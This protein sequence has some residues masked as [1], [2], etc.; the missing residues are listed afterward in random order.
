MTWAPRA[1]QRV[2]TAHFGPGVVTRATKGGALVR[3]E[4][5]GGYEIEV[6]AGELSPADG[7][8]GERPAA[9]VGVA[10]PAAAPVAGDLAARRAIEALRFGL[11]PHQYLE[12]LTLGFAELR[13][14]TLRNFPAAHDDRPRVA[15]I[16]G[17]FGT[18]KSHT[19][20]VIRHLAGCEGYVT[21][22][23]EVD[24]QQISLAKPETFLYQLWSTAAAPDLS[25]ST[26]LLDLYA[27]A[28]AAGQPPPEVVPDGAGGGDR[29][30]QNYT[31]VQHLHR[32]GD[33]DNHGHALDAILSSSTEFNAA[34]VTRLIGGRIKTAEGSVAVK[35]MLGNSVRERPYDLV[36]SLAGHALVARLA[37]YRGLIVTIDEFEVEQVPSRAGYERVKGALGV[38]TAY[39]Q[40]RTEHRPAPLG[41]FFATVGEDEHGGD[42]VIRR[43]LDATG[44]DE[45]R[46]EPRPPAQR[47]EL[48]R[49]IHRLYCAAYA[50]DRDFDPAIV[51]RIE[52]GFVEAGLDDSR[53]IRAFIKR[54]VGTLDA[55]FGPPASPAPASERSG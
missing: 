17:P 21:A 46:L 33:L 39:L 42:E 49:R 25:S 35:R 3:L 1:G 5:L 40:G 44:G 24:G 18:G 12:D 31:V 38:L 27:R 10:A 22:R 45:H 9:A 43:M 16:T 54:Y 55:R 6:A 51:E 47:L 14:W 15:A 7:A 26:L 28:V 19:M 2:V 48:A 30:R 13:D 41:L 37:G 52:Q 36:G 29:V 20:A 32:R 34:E 8:A 53:L 23:V 4:G 11:V 50:V